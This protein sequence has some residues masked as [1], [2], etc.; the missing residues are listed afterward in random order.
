MKRVISLIASLLLAL[1]VPVTAFAAA[2]SV[3]FIDKK[4][5][6]KFIVP[7]GWKLINAENIEFKADFCFEYQEPDE[8][9][10]EVVT[11]MTYTSAEFKSEKKAD[12]AALLG[13]P[14]KSLKKAEYNRVNYFRFE[15]NADMFTPHF[16]KDQECVGYVTVNN[17]FIYQI[18]FFDSVE[19]PI[20]DDFKSLMG[21]IEIKG[22]VPK[23]PKQGKLFTPAKLAAIAV[24]FASLAAFII[25][26][27]KTKK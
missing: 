8:E 19:N 9:E 6:T 22:T 1:L 21:S 26:L 13:I 20:Y 23:A 24:M 11:Y 12:I 3:E 15:T 10:D 25:V 14:E 16:G 27:I 2:S 5:E 17:G 7:S 18:M 4:T